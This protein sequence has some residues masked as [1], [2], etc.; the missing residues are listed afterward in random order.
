MIFIKESG[1]VKAGLTRCD[2]TYILLEFFILV[3]H[4]NLIKYSKFCIEMLKTKFRCTKK[5]FCCQHLYFGTKDHCP[6]VCMPILSSSG[7]LYFHFQT[8][9]CV[10]YPWTKLIH[11]VNQG[12]FI[13]DL[14]IENKPRL[15]DLHIIHIAFRSPISINGLKTI[16]C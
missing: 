3:K 10:Q 4:R 13:N 15:T 1:L 2:C 8:L 16:L 11:Q 14:L 12:I 5:R 6:L 7:P 9:Q